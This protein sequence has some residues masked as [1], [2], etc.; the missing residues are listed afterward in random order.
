MIRKPAMPALTAI[1]ADW[2][3]RNPKIRR[4]WTCETPVPDAVAV[5]LELQPVA[6]SEETSAV[7]LAHCEEWRRELQ[8]RVHRSVDLEWLDP[9]EA[10]APNQPRPAE[11]GT[12]IYERAS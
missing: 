1:I 2:A 3:A 7:W 6:D 5:A 11:V 4:V 9:D 8:R 10:S 12:L